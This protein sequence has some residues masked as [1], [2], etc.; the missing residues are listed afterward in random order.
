MLTIAAAIMLTIYKTKA[1]MLSPKR[2]QSIH[3]TPDATH[4]FPLNLCSLL[5]VSALSVFHLAAYS[6]PARCSVFLTSVVRIAKPKDDD[7][8]K[9]F[10][11]LFR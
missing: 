11:S 5:L 3:K 9:L 2:P 6:H 4:N 10:Y 8:Q 7:K 1:A